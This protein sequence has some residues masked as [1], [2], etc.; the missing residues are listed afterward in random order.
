MQFTKH[1]DRVSVTVELSD[2]PETVIF[3]CF[4]WYT[5][6]YNV[7]VESIAPGAKRITVAGRSPSA[8]APNVISDLQTRISRDLID[9]RTRQIVA[10]ETRLLR[11][12]I[13]AKAFEPAEC[14]GIYPPGAFSDIAAHPDGVDDLPR[15]QQD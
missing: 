11:Q 1:A 2:F 6:D 9:F 12:L 3:K 4:Y 14:H 8:L 10:D 15:T 5:H 13:V 7:S